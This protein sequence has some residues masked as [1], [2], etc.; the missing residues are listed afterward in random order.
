MS[1]Q[2]DFTALYER[3]QKLAPG[4]KAELRRVVRPSDLEEYPTVYRLFPGRPLN[5]ALLRVA[6]CLPWVEHREDAPRLGAQLADAKVSEQ[7]LFQVMRS[8]Y[9][10]DLIQ[11]RR[12]LQQVEP[13]ANWRHLGPML[14]RWS[15]GDKRRLIE[16]YYVRS[17]ADGNAA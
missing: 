14:M 12:L 1:E 16:E 15:R 4:P 11:F 17:S 8:T 5:E 2:I 10:N 7:R 9:P 3:F 6:Y 13:L